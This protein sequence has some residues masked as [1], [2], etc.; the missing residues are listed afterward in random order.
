VDFF[1]KIP[2][3]IFMILNP[4]LCYRRKRFMILNP[5]LCYRRKRFMILNPDLL[6]KKKIHDTEPRSVTEEKDS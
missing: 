2:E 4:D 6:Q 1:R 3:Q 5:D